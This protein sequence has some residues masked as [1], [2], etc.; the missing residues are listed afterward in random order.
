[1]IK[2]LR[3]L[4]V[5][6]MC[7]NIVKAIYDK[8]TANIILSSEKLI[9]FPLKSGTRQGCPLSPL[10]FNIVLEFLARAVRQEEEIKGIQ[11]G[12]ETVKISLFADDMILYLKDPKNSAQNILDTIKSYTK[13]AGYKINLQKSLGFLYTNN[14]QTEKEYMETIPFTIASK[15]KYLGVNLTKDVNDLYKENYKLLRK[16]IE[17]D[18]RRWKD[19]PCSWIGRINIVKMTTLTKA[20]Y[21]FN[22]IPIKIPI[23]FI[24]EIEKST[25]KFI[26]KHKIP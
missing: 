13:V 9:Q 18:Y 16:E 10:L 11:I 12:K 5:E 2:A 6:G 26:W 19:L 20:I 17:E 1:M 22:A 24:T 4:G 25:L 23:T 15:N 7:L 21:M 3:K 14:E 8:P